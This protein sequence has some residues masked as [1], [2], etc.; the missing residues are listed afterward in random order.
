MTADWPRNRIRSELLLR[1]ISLTDIDREGNMK[2]GSASKALMRPW[3]R[4]EKLIAGKLNL[5]PKDIWPSRY[6]LNGRSIDR[7]GRP[8]CEEPKAETNQQRVGT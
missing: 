3:N 1:G 2:K 7:R 5:E 8:R 6:H 4:M